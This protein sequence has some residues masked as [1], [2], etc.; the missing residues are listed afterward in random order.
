MAS[1]AATDTWVSCHQY[2]VGEL[3]GWCQRMKSST[4]LLASTTCRHDVCS[5]SVLSLSNLLSCARGPANLEKPISVYCQRLGL[6]CRWQGPKYKVPPNVWNKS[7]KIGF[8]ASRDGGMQGWVCWDQMSCDGERKYK[9]QIGEI[10]HPFQIS[11]RFFLN[12]NSY[13]TTQLQSEYLIANLSRDLDDLFKM[14]KVIKLKLPSTPNLGKFESY[15]MNPQ[16][17]IF[18]PDNRL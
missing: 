18:C 2:L 5:Y 12:I 3:R 1:L 10:F 4:L 17:L 13:Y 16:I 6:K 7:K 9:G 15:S 11:W 14:K 8:W